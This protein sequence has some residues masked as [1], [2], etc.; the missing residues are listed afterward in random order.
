MPLLFLPRR[1]SLEIAEL[2]RPPFAPALESLELAHVPVPEHVAAWAGSLPALRTLRLRSCGGA[3]DDTLLALRGLRGLRCLELADLSVSSWGLG[4]LLAALPGL[5]QLSLSLASLD[6]G[7]S[8]GLQL[9]HMAELEELTLRD[10]QA[11][12]DEELAAVVAQPKVCVPVRME[13]WGRR[14]GGGS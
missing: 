1:L 6:R 7:V 9:A 2:L 13:P 14:R 5:A 12:A 11:M 10:L 4:R 3:A 8:A